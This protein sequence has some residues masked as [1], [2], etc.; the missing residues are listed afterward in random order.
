M[1]ERER[2]EDHIQECFSEG[3]QGHLRLMFL[4]AYSGVKIWGSFNVKIGPAILA[5]RERERERE[6]YRRS[7]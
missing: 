1:R 6:S 4:G 5:S 3:F 2:E 7:S